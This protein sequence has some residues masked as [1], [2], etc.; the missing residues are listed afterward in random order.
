MIMHLKSIN[1]ESLGIEEWTSRINESPWEWK[2][3]QIL[4]VNSGGEDKN[5]RIKWEK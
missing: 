2:I 3:E 5:G 1:L 4:W